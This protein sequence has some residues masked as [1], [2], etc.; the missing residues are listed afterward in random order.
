MA[1]IQ[2]VSGH[3]SPRYAAGATKVWY[4]RP[5]FFVD[6]I[7]GHDWLVE[8]GTLPQP[9]LVGN[10]ERT[11]VL[12]G[13]LNIDHPEEA[14]EMMQGENWSPEGEARHLIQ[15]LGLQHTSMSVGDIIEKD[16]A[17]WMVDGVGFKKLGAS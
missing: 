1:T 12:V 14:W 8:K 16:G 15:A 17:F 6:G 3:I 10:L 2:S 9:H 7:M 4:M 5:R 11:H 13:S